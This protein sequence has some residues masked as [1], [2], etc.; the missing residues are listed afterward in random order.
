MYKRK[1]KPVIN[2]NEFKN[3]IDTS[4]YETSKD[5]Y[6]INKKKTPFTDIDY[7][8]NNTDF[9]R[10]KNYTFIRDNKNNNNS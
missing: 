10:V 1:I 2:L 8:S 7:T 5:K 3:D 6:N 4:M 9:N